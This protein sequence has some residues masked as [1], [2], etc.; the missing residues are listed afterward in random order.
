VFDCDFQDALLILV[1][2]IE[3]STKHDLL[4]FEIFVS[5]FDMWKGRHLASLRH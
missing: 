2:Y 5:K 4:S 3:I 1:Q